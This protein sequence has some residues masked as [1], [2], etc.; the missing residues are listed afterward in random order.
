MQDQYLYQQIVQSVRARI[1][2]GELKPGDRLPTIR[3][4]TLRWGCTPGTVQRAY[5]ELARQGLIMSRPGQGTHVLQVPSEAGELPLRRAKLVNR[6][7]SFL[8]EML[9]AGFSPNEVETALRLALDQWR[10]TAVE[11]EAPAQGALRFSG[12]HDLALAWI[13]AH[14]FEISPGFSLELNFSGSLGGLVALSEGRADLA[15]VHLWDPETDSYNLPYVRRVLPGVRLALLTLAWRRQGL[16]VPR[17]NPRR[18]AQV[19]DLAQPGLRFVNRQPGSGTRV[20]LDAALQRRGIDPRRISGYEQVKYTHTEVAR[21]IAEQEADAGFGLQTAAL[22]F[23]LD[24]IPLVDER[25]DLVLPEA[26]LKAPA[27]ENLAAWLQTGAAHKVI[28]E[29]GGYDTRETGRLTWVG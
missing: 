15:G 29:L 21:A 13:A 27:A 23:G 28:A 20:W 22:A 7:Q 17:G 16:I 6:A 11:K 14:F 19:S 4:Q 26:C 25:Y 1:L 8:L 18:L 10:V 2:D 9:T 3:E 12:S 24:F 5:H